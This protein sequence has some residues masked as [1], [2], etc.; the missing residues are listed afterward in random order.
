MKP[1]L[2]LALAASLTLASAQAETIA[3]A[4]D[5]ELKTQDIREALAGL[6]GQQQTALSK[7]P[8]AIGQ[9]VRALIIQKLVL[10]QAT[11]KKFDQDP[12]VIAKLVRARE[13][14]LTEAYL[15]SFS[16]P[17]AGYPNEDELKAAY[18]SAKPSLLLPKGYR[19]AQIFVKDEAKLAD[20]RTKLKAKDADFAA[21][22]KAHSEEAASAAKGGEIGWLTEQQIQP[23][24]KDK[25]PAL[26]AGG[27]AGEPVKLDDGWHILKLLEV[28]EPATATFDQVRASLAA[29][30][31]TD[32]SKELRQQ[33]LATL[34]KD[35]PVAINEIELSKLLAP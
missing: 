23:A 33:F 17:P 2:A 19:L 13:T 1:L 11:E 29:R 24:I 27:P 8:A 7:D 35:H 25:L 5:F 31:R 3:K 18:E 16:Q 12:A 4:G 22:A 28:R 30:L 34:L 15:E 6:E 10:Q 21:I 26:K 32:K 20:I 14:A 9:Y